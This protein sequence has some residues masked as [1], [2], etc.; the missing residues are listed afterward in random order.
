MKKVEINVKLILMKK[1][2]HSEEK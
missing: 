1:W 2:L